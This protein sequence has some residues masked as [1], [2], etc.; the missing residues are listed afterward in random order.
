MW[1]IERLKVYSVVEDLQNNTQ[2][3]VEFADN[4][5]SLK[6]KEFFGK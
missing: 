6:S 4:L 5:G 2:N 1:L 3:K